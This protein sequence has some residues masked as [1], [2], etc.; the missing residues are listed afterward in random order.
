MCA[1]T[2]VEFNKPLHILE[3]PIPKPASN[4]IIIRVLASSLC[5]SDLAGWMGVVG[6]VTPYVPVTSL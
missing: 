3:L 2:V 5:N 1:A 4:Q 6:A